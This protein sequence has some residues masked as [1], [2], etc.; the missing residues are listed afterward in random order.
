VWATIALGTIWLFY[1]VFVGL[2]LIVGQI[3]CFRETCRGLIR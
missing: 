3:F 2:V 1:A